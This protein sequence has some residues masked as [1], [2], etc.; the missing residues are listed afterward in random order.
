VHL[1]DDGL[2]ALDV[3][4]LN[5]VG[6][7]PIV[8]T[9]QLDGK[10]VVEVHELP[11][12]DRRLLGMA[13]VDLSQTISHMQPVANYHVNQRPAFWHRIDHD[14]SLGTFDHAPDLSWQIRDLL[15][16]EHVSTHVDALCHYT[17]GSDAWCMER[18]PLNWFISPAVCIDLS[19]VQ[20]DAFIE[21][22]DIEAAL[23]H[24]GLR[25]RSGDTFLYHQSYYSRN[26]SPPY[27]DDWTGL[28]RDATLWLA[29]QGVRNIGCETPSIDNSRAMANDANPCFPAHRVCRDRQMINTENLADLAPV[30]GKRFLYIGLPLKL[31]GGTGCPVR[32]IALVE[33]AS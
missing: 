1:V 26:P 30:V 9:V 19:H 28:S 29:D 4:K 21:R 5:P 7:D 24:A 22:S 12:V 25:L 2:R 15:I 14:S 11:S 17:A 32:A 20:S 16:G 23:D 6:S 3:E 18:M 33:E 10:D 27:P 31:R 13:I 8:E